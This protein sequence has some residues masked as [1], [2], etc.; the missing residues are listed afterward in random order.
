MNTQL[1]PFLPLRALLKIHL[2]SEAFPGHSNLKSNPTTVLPNTSYTPPCFI[3]PFHHWSPSNTFCTCLLSAIPAGIFVRTATTIVIHCCIPSAWNNVWHAV[4]WNKNLTSWFEL[5][6]VS[7]ILFLS[8]NFLICKMGNTAQSTGQRYLD[9]DDQEGKGN[10]HVSLYLHC[11]APDRHT[12]LW[13]ENKLTEYVANYEPLLHNR[14][15]LHFDNNAFQSH[16]FIWQIFPCTF[17]FRVFVLGMETI[18]SKVHE[19]HLSVA[20]HPGWEVDKWMTSLRTARCGCHGCKNRG[21]WDEHR[22]KWPHQFWGVGGL[23]QRKGHLQEVQ[24]KVNHFA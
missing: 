8:F 2:L 9:C 12:N 6:V 19:C 15:T 22:R 4:A 10:L 16:L 7:S 3:F 14:R 5:L 17:L 21:P 1:V 20:C 23:P 18:K 13:E 11:L 24:N